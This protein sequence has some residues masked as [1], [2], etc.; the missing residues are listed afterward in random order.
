MSKPNRR[1]Q[2]RA[3]ARE[4]RAAYAAEMKAK[5]DEAMKAGHRRWKYPSTRPRSPREFVE[6]SAFGGGMGR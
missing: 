3:E 1:K 2:R 5:Q 4:R 6:V